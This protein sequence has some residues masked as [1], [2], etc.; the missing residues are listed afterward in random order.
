[1]TPRPEPDARKLHLLPD[2]DEAVEELYRA[3]APTLFRRALLL[4]QGNHKQAEE[5][6]Q[7]VFHDAIIS[8]E[9]IGR[10]DSGAQRAWL[11]K[12]LHNKAAD[13]WRQKAREYPFT[14]FV[15]NQ[16]PPIQGPDQEI[17]RLIA[18]ERVLK[19]INSMPPVRHRVAYL[20]LLAGFPTRE[21]ARILGINQSTV[22]GHLKDALRDLRKEVGPI[23]PDTDPD[24]GRGQQPKERR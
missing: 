18:L 4:T 2:Q 11:H 16:L 15:S 9:K 3:A 13:Y 20:R 1:V 23:L 7:I 17:L 12:V 8:W 19:V 6:V 10:R 22:R 5:L 24:P 14:D 21:I